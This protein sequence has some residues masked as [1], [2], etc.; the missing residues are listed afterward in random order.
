MDT[1]AYV[2]PTCSVDVDPTHSTSKER[3]PGAA[4]LRLNPSI[5][6]HVLA[7]ERPAQLIL[8]LVQHPGLQVDTSTDEQLVLQMVRLCLVYS[9]NYKQHEKG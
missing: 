1:W 9:P 3:L 6:Q 5:E 2:S 7:A 4:L 8:Q